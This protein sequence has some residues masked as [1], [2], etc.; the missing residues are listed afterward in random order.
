[1]DCVDSHRCRKG[2]GEF[3]GGWIL[4]V[5][6]SC[7]S[8]INGRTATGN[9][10]SQLAVKHFLGPNYDLYVYHMGQ[11]PGCRFARKSIIKLICSLQELKGKA[12]T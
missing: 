10:N 4:R 2:H 11:P 7:T 6:M 1:M 3:W 8:E 12:C 9:K 5:A